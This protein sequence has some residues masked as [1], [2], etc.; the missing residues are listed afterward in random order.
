[1]EGRL[2]REKLETIF[3]QLIQRHESLRTSFIVVDDQPVQRVHPAVEVSMEYY[4]AQG[5]DIP[6]MIDR[7]IRPFDLSCAPLVRLGLIR[8]G[9]GDDRHI[10]MLDM[11]HIITDGVSMGI[12]SNEV[13]ALYAGRDLPPVRVQYRDFSIWQG[14]L[15][16]FGEMEK[17]EAYW[18]KQ[19]Q[20]EIPQLDLTYDFPRPSVPSGKGGDVFFEIDEE[21]AAQVFK[22]V[23]ESGTT[24]YVF[25]LSICYVLFSKYT[26]RDDIVLGTSTAGRSHADLENIIGMFVNMLALRNRPKKEKTFRDFLEEVNENL[27]DAFANQDYQFEDL[28]RKL[29]LQVKPGRNPLFDFIFKLQNMDIPEIK[30][31][32]LVL[33]P[34]GEYEDLRARFDLVI[35]ANEIG[36]VIGVNFNYSADL[37]EES[38]IREMGNHFMEVLQ[39]VLRNPRVS[40]KEVEISTVFSA[41]RSTLKEQETVFDF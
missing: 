18:L 17:M 34:Y 6:G 13:M 5:G 7:F 39:Q 25:L 40:M 21:T 35:S 36:K 20:G 37:F 10:L 38:T 31:E 11:H 3:K 4:E 8:V 33:K 30:M 14:R 15:V 29:N 16:E 27:M 32:G 24:L 2:D 19:F 1:L 23:K 22:L 26:G 41:A 12:F 9:E 28:V